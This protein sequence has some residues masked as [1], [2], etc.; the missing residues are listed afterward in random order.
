MGPFPV[1]SFLLPEL[2]PELFSLQLFFLLDPFRGGI[3]IPPGP[4]NL[5][6]PPSTQKEK[7]K[8]KMKYFF[9][10]MEVPCWFSTF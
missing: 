6:S 10:F 1:G 5:P 8:E 4:S 9:L 2:I 7:E 3:S